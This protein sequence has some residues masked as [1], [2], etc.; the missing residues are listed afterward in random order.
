MGVPCP[1]CCT[2][3][4]VDLFFVVLSVSAMNERRFRGAPT[5][6]PYSNNASPALPPTTPPHLTPRE[7]YIGILNGTEATQRFRWLVPAYGNS[8]SDGSNFRSHTASLCIYVSTL[9]K[10]GLSPISLQQKFNAQNG[11]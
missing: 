2:A 10:I 1:F 4:L 5:G 11:R 8:V 3:Y 6:D 7:L 9:P